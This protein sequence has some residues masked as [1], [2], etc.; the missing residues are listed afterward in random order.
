M[1]RPPASADRARRIRAGAATFA[2]VLAA[3]LAGAAAADWLQP[4]P[5]YREQQFLLRMAMRDTVG[6]PDDPG[7]LDS[8]ATALLRLDRTEEA[9][10]LFARILELRPGDDRA[11]A[12]LGKLALFAGRLEEAE[13][14]LAA[15]DPADPAARA[16][17]FAARIRR[18]DYAAA[19]AMTPEVNQEGRRP[20]LERMAE[21]PPCR[22]VSGPDEAEVMWSR[23]YP[24]PLV[25]VL[26]NGQRVLM[27]IDTGADDILLDESAARRYKVTEITG[28]R[29]TFWAGGRTV[30]SNAM[31][32][33]LELGGFRIENLPAGVLSLR[34]WSIEVNTYREPVV[35]IIGLNLLRRF[36]PTLDY[37]RQRLVLRRPEAPIEHSAGAQRVPFEVWGEA[38]VM[39][40]GTLGSERRMAF[41]V[42]TGLPRC[43][44]AAPAEVF[45]EIGV[46]AGVVSRA[47]KGAGTWLRGRPWA[48]VTVPA[49]TVGPIVGDRVPGWLGAFDSSE[50][51]RHGVRR[52]ALISHDFFRDRRLTF[53]W[54]AGELI[55][56]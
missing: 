44:V 1:I 52:D 31:V 15:S 6:H 2:V 32:Q 37:A 20:L 14:L 18:G 26:L 29:L 35:G 55:F 56:E 23:A 39:V 17:L 45:E 47:V 46:K 8:L 3:S 40:R 28:R 4:D 49:V 21:T 38:E 7:R 51:W 13:R 16:D 53:D 42:Q 34:R 19:A 50:M 9:G 5:S 48:E 30:V 10:R 22:I 24:V 11:E 54:K 27:A 25:R 36:T 33:R 12:A 43:G 41:V